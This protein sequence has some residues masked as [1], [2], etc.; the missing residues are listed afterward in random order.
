MNKI[1]LK[2]ILFTMIILFLG[3]FAGTKTT[4]YA[5]N[6]KEIQFGEYPQ[7]EVDF[8]N[9]EELFKQLCKLKDMTQDNIIEYQGKRYWKANNGFYKYEPISWIW[10]SGDSS[11]ALLISKYVLD[12]HTYGLISD[13]CVSWENADLRKWC[14]ADFMEKAFS[15]EEQEC[16]YSVPVSS[17]DWNK[18]NAME[19]TEKVTI[20]SHELIQGFSEFLQQG[21]GTDYS[22]KGNH[23]YHTRCTGSYYGVCNY[24]IWVTADNKFNS[25]YPA[26]WSRGVRPCIVLDL[27]MAESVEKQ[28]EESRRRD[29][30]KADISLS[31]NTFK[32]DGNK[33]TPSVKVVYDGKTLD[34]SAYSLK[35]KN[36]RYAGTAVV[37]ISGVGSYTGTVEK[38]FI[39]KPGKQLKVRFDGNGG[40]VSKNQINLKA[41][42]RYS[43]LPAVKRS[44]YKLSGWYTDK[45]GGKKVTKNTYVTAKKNHTLYARW[46]KETYKITYNLDGGK[47]SKKNPA[48]YTVST[49]TIKFTSPSKKGYEFAGWYADSKFKKK[50][51]EIVKGSAGN[52]KVYAKWIP[53]T[54][55]V[56]F[57]GNLSRVTSSMMPMTIKYGLDYS[58]NKNTFKPTMAG[59]EFAGW[60]LSQGGNT[61]FEDK[62]S[63][64]I[65]TL[66]EQY[67]VKLKRKSQIKLYAQWRL[68]EYTISYNVND[69]TMPESYTTIFNVT[70]TV[71]LPQPVKEGYDFKGWYSGSKAV[72]KIK[73]G[74]AKNFSLTAKWKAIT[75]KIVY[76]ANGG[77][78]KTDETNCKYDETYEIR[79]NGF[80]NGNK[81]FLSWN[82]QPD[83]SGTTFNV[84]DNVKNL[85]AKKTTIKL[86]AQ[87]IFERAI[88]PMHVMSVEQVAYESFSHKTLNAIDISGDNM[89]APFTGH[90]ASFNRSYG[91]VIFVSES[92]VLYADG[93]R[94]YMTVELLHASNLDELETLYNNKT[95]IKQGTVFYHQGKTGI[96]GTPDEN[97]GI[98]VEV[99]VHK[100]ITES[101]FSGDVYAFDAFWVDRSITKTIWNWGVCKNGNYLT[102][103]TAPS[104]WKDRWRLI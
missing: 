88:F 87:W 77:T 4:V 33:K 51:T 14:N 68:I 91:K 61:I 76:D 20:P 44:G 2:N 70:D 101:N 81:M 58:L 99:R 83:G 52:K 26:N 7:S 1:H 86:Y 25:D 16:I 8:K 48:S 45:K 40:K 42:M 32:Y 24:P 93:T 59:Y 60:S 21:I 62:G 66:T 89:F 63:I 94:D 49:K 64:S 27:D 95:I 67:G 46:K 41:G 102:V 74:T 22:G 53:Y 13:A 15:E 72:K 39:I 29:L 31:K 34:E 96:Y 98:H 19:T 23:D 103:S 78:G 79:D 69:G 10:V 11:R 12:N 47:N 71:N 28:K 65:K 38:T 57:D 50:V 43:S 17:C 6:E 90:I 9:E 80:S 82:T 55:T 30:T 97:Y 56:N 3:L 85:A 100:G 37:E 75:Y 104:N 73:K 35:Y 84:G 54:L 36:N 92:K 5:E 18:E